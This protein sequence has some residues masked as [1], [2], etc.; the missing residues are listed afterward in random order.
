MY[1]S[2]EVEVQAAAAGL[3]HRL[4]HEGGKQPVAGQMCIR[5]RYYTAQKGE[6]RAEVTLQDGRG[7]TAVETASYILDK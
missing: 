4:G 3:R 6:Y 1:K 5:D 7:R 2:Q